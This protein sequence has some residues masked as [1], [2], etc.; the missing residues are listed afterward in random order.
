MK[1]LRHIWGW[2]VGQCV[3]EVP[4]DTAL[5]E[6]ECRKPQ[7]YDGE[8]ESCLRRLQRGAGELMPAREPNAC[9]GRAGRDDAD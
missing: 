7:C 9:A 4:V 1:L 5:C 8:W 2:V 6:F 3:R